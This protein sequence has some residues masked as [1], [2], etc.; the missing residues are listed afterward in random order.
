MII[1]HSSDIDGTLVRLDREE[2]EHCVRVLRHRSGDEI[3]VIDGHGGLLKCRLTDDNPKGASAE[4]IERIPNFGS[5]PYNLT[6][7]VCPT[8]NIDRFEW[9]AEKATEI[10]V[11]AIVPLIGERSERKIL[12]TER[13]SR[14]VLSATKQSLKGTVPQ[15]AEPVSVRDFI[16]TQGSDSEDC[17]KLICYCMDDESKRISIK[18]ALKKHRTSRVSILIGPEGDFSPEEISLAFE[19][20]WQPV[21][22]GESRL[23]TETAAL[24][25]VTAV[26]L[27]YE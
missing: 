11:D 6:M 18:E 21:H 22:L 14:L 4:I 7:G 2:S 17:L 20:G 19:H 1:F 26:Y 24:V 12:K 27:Q 9:F 8:K 23:R 15:I 13:L 3:S 10:G 16:E 5:H 25:A